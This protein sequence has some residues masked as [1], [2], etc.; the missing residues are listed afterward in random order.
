MEK[1]LELINNIPDIYF[2]DKNSDNYCFYNPPNLAAANIEDMV[3]N[4]SDIIKEYKKLQ[5]MSIYINVP[6]CGSRCAYCNYFLHL[7]NNKSNDFLK[8]TLEEFNILNKEIDLSNKKIKSVYFGGGT[9][10]AISL[11]YLNIFLSSINDILEKDEKCETTFECCPEEGVKEKFNLL[12]RKGITRLSFG[13]E[14][15]DDKILKQLNRRHD[16]KMVEDVINCA[17]NIFE[18]INI[19]IIYGL[20]NQTVN[21][22]INTVNKS[23]ALETSGITIYKLST[24]GFG[25]SYRDKGSLMFNK[26]ENNI[27]SLPYDKLTAMMYFEAREVLLK[28]GFIEPLV[29]FFVKPKIN[30]IKVYKDRWSKAMP[31]YGLGLGAFSYGSFGYLGNTDEQ[32]KYLDNIKN[33]ELPIKKVKRFGSKESLLFRFL[34]RLKSGSTFQQKEI[35]NELSLFMDRTLESFLSL[36]F[37]KKENGDFSLT[38]L[39]RAFVDRIAFDVLR[40]SKKI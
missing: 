33:N 26:H 35:P 28:E 9:P 32:K 7:Y 20:P 18:N 15:L 30:D 14:T 37:I 25:K 13:V 6:F 29:G 40:I 23:I 11:D 31:V 34:G 21:E 1:Y 5:E 24:F 19:D 17:K 2:Q 39:G 3:D 16:S 10:S 36:G 22:W 27:N 8:N 38:F 4:L 12:K